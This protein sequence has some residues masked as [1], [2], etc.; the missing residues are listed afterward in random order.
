MMKN[1]DDEDDNHDND[2]INDNNF[3]NDNNNNNN[4]TCTVAYLRAPVQSAVV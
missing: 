3:V 2:E 1:H 4:K